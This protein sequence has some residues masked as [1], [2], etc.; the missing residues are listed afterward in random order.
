M[1]STSSRVMAVLTVVAMLA[2][3]IVAG[4]GLDRSMLRKRS[5]FRTG[6]GSPGGPRGGPF[7]AM[8]EPVDTAHRNRMRAR[9]VKNIAEDLALTPTQA[10]A[11]DAI[12]ARR[13]LQLDSLRS[14]V[15][16]QLDSLRD[17]MRMSIDSVLTPDQRTKFAAR[18][19][20]REA[21]HR[22][23]KRDDASPPHY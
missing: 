14:H 15:G 20:E 11:V 9:I 21:R 2:I 3:G 23:G 22:E 6:Q 17:Q 1:T 13:E 18:R 5:D 7:G 8:T 10:K 19:K 4:I 12:F 16:P